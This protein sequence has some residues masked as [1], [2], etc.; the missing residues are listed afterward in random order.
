M[1]NRSQCVGLFLQA[2][3]NSKKSVSWLQTGLQIKQFTLL[4]EINEVS[5]HFLPPDAQY[6]HHFSLPT[7]LL[8]SERTL[9]VTAMSHLAPAV[10][11][12]QNRTNTESSRRGCR[13]VLLCPTR[14]LAL[15]A[16]DLVLPSL[17]EESWLSGSGE[18]K[19]HSPFF[20]LAGFRLILGTLTCNQQ[21][22]VTSREPGL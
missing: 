2:L 3:I 9:A 6:M 13:A 18:E 12:G 10:C 5:K 20:W 4:Q 11:P 1:S 8:M 22:R 17:P 7:Y 14:L 19:P 21:T 15:C 16:N